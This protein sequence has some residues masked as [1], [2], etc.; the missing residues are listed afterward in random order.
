MASLLTR[1]NSAVLFVTNV[2][3]RAWRRRAQFGVYG[4]LICSQ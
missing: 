2:R 1:S 4:Q 3:P